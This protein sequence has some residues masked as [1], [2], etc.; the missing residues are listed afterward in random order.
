MFLPITWD[1]FD[2]SSLRI[3]LLR[4]NKAVPQKVRSAISATSDRLFEEL[5]DEFWSGLTDSPRIQHNFRGSEAL[6]HCRSCLTQLMVGLL[7]RE[8]IDP[9]AFIARQMRSGAAEANRQI[10]LPVVVNATISAKHVFSKHVLDQNFSKD[11]YSHAFIYISAVIDIS[12]AAVVAGYASEMQ[13]SARADEALREISVG[14]DL[15]AER[16]KQKAALAEW[17]QD[18]FFETALVR[19]TGSAP[20]LSRSE[21]G[22][23]FS[24]RAHLL[25]GHKLEYAS[26]AALIE[27]ADQLVNQLNGS[28]VDLL[29]QE[30]LKDIKQISDQINN[31]MVAQFSRFLD[32]GGTRDPLSR[33]LNRRF[34]KAAIQREMTAYRRTGKTFSLVMFEI[35]GFAEL[36]ARLGEDGADA[37]VQQTAA[38]LLN[39]VR[40]SDVVI[41]MGRETFLVIRVEAELPE[42]RA[43]AQRIVASYRAAHFSIEGQTVQESTLTFGVASYDG[44]SDSRRLVDLVAAALHG[45]ESTP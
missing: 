17:A 10:P 5:G 16:E 19:A 11:Y 32:M 12:A 38:F 37:M 4:L 36:R 40:S 25:F 2:V 43:F 28:K 33:L 9:D 42:A 30:C 1:D 6:A 14:H 27:R 22:L 21:F 3:Q 23:W 44:V 8:G 18:V 34:L 45:G 15:R 39:A 31:L 29:R 20:L 24:H 26:T 35:P 13:R 7:P 41:S